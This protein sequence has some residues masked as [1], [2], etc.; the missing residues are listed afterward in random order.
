MVK[1]LVPSSF[2]LA[3]IT[4]LGLTTYGTL[5]NILFCDAEGIPI[6]CDD[7]FFIPLSESPSGTACAVQYRLSVF[8]S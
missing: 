7:S 6:L 8:S 5:W 4:L 2:F 3:L 1:S